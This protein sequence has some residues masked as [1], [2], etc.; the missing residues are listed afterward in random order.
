[1][2]EV[3]KLLRATAANRFEEEGRRKKEVGRRKASGLK[4]I[5]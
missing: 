4:L 3:I 5:V 2:S 1:M